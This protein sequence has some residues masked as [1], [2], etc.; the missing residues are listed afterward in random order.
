[1]LVR[2]QI[3]DANATPINTS[4]ANRPFKFESATANAAQAGC[5]TFHGNRAFQVGRIVLFSVKWNKRVSDFGLSREAD[6]F[7]YS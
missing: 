7:S 5:S 1:M 4:C 3:G 2:G 6:V